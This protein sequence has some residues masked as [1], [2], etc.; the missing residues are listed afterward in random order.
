MLWPDWLC[1][2]TRRDAAVLMRKRGSWF[3]VILDRRA[4][5]AVRENTV[6]VIKSSMGKNYIKWDKAPLA[7][8][9]LND[10]EGTFG[11]KL[12][13]YWVL[14]EQMSEEESKIRQFHT[15]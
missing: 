7:A 14:Q 1:P 2:R 9:F 13:E 4:G 11:D 8:I 6:Q 3:T 10:S 12:A 15:W 5:Y